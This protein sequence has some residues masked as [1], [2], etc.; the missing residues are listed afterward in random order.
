MQRYVQASQ[1][2][3]AEKINTFPQKRARLS[4]ANY[5]LAISAGLQ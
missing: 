1:E 3:A 5:R 4:Q 2:H